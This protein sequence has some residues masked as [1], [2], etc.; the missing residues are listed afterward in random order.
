MDEEMK[1]LIAVFRFGVISDFV[2]GSILTRGKSDELMQEKCARQWRIPGSSRTSIGES[3]IKEW[4]CRYKRSGNKLEALYPLERSDKGK[5]RAIEKETA[6]GLITLR[7]EFR[8]V[9]LPIFISRAKERKVIL[10]GRHI[11]YATVYRFLKAEGLIQQPAGLPG[12]RRKFEAAYPNDLWQSD[13]MH[14]PRVLWEGKQRKTYLIA[15][16]DDMSR[17]VPYAE[18]YLH[19]RLE[20]FLEAFRKALRMRGLPRKLYVDNGPSFRSNHLEHTCASLGIVLLHAKPYQPEGKGKIERWFGTVRGSFL[21]AYKPSTFEELKARFRAWVT[22]YNETGHSSTGN[23]PMKRFADNIECI[24]PAPKDL[25]DHFR[26]TAKRTVAKDRTIAL[27]GRLYEAPVELIG[28]QISLLYH[29]HDPA[30]VELIFAGKTYG[31]LSQVD[32]HVNY[33]IKR[34]NNKVTE[35]E[36]DSKPGK[37]ASGSLFKK[38]TEEDK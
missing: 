17:L 21:A 7:K 23:T 35:I 38:T 20:S 1:K 27:A 9:S 3:T 30:R 33:R 6:A 11:P 32:V 29:E 25:E 28:K 31:F 4:A 2:G 16:I 8:E 22:G 19:E 18:F 36:A 15:F 34:N 12:D 26:K 10:P 14:G 5:P 13:V 24:R 37:Y